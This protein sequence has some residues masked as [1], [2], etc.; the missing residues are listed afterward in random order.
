VESVAWASERR[1]VLSGVFWQLGLLAFAFAARGAHPR[2]AHAALFASFGLGL[3][4][5][6]SVVT[7]PFVLLLLDAWP[8]GRLGRRGRGIAARALARAFVE[9]LPLFALSAAAC[10]MTLRAQS[11]AG[12]VLAL[13]RLPVAERV[14]NALVAYVVYLRR[15]LWP[16]DLA[17]FYP[18]SGSGLPFWQPLGAG[19]L[20]LALTLLALRAWPRRGYLAVGW[21]WFLGVLV[22]M[23]GLVQVGSQAL[24]DRYM[25]L[26][27]TGL[28]IALA[29]G[30]SDAVGR[31]ARRRTAAACV[32]LLV[33]GAL[34]WTTRLQLRHWRDSVSLFEHALAVTEGNAVAHT[35]L[36]AAYSERG[37]IGLSIRHY[38]EAVRLRPDD[39]IA[40]NN[41]AWLLATA[42]DP[43]LRDPAFAVALAERAASLSPIPSPDVL[44]TLAA[45]YASAGRFDD[46]VRTL[47]RALVWSDA[48]AAPAPVKRLRERLGLYR[49]K[50]AYFE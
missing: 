28:A 20:L 43:S 42:R 39:V 9:K 48:D 49:A 1:D 12:V 19:L 41:L 33:V 21:L 17:V 6:P 15:F 30:V 3:L 29:W 22:P 16:S 45:A 24:A 37:Q 31:H 40:L 47:E 14:G 46:A 11:A 50:R 36:G 32:A 2:S 13:E 8:L 5:K 10:W 23:I 18:L 38:W 35:Q 25:Y 34:A 4:A 7:L 27:L 44:D 26:P